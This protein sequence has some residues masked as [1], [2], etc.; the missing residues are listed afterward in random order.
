MKTIKLLQSEIE[1]TEEILH[2]LKNQWNELLIAKVEKDL[3]IKV[4]T[5]IEWQETKNLFTGYG[6][7]RRHVGE[8]TTTR[9]AV[10]TKYDIRYG[11]PEPVWTVLKKDGHV[12]TKKIYLREF[13]IIG[14]YDLKKDQMIPNE[15]PKE[16]T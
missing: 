13:H 3:G 8:R 2:N 14:E 9:K 16:N 4:G 1:Q 7:R 15:T 10:L 5:V 6:Y 12:G 11:T